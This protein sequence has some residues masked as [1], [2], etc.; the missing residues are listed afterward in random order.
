MPAELP[1]AAGGRHLLQCSAFPLYIKNE[2]QHKVK[3]A[4]VG[5]LSH[6]TAPGYCNSTATSAGDWCT[7]LWV[8]MDPQQTVR[9]FA[10]LTNPE[11][12]V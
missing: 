12:F 1:S 3:L 5:Q 10:D 4:I 8:W 11:F 9:A 2:C 6:D 7:Q